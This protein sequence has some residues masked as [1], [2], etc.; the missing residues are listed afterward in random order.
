MTKAPRPLRRAPRVRTPRVGARRLHHASENEGFTLVEVLIALMVLALATMYLS[1]GLTTSAW[2]VQ[3]TSSRIAAN[4]IAQQTLQQAESL[5]YAT[6]SEGI[7]CP[8]SGSSGCTSIAR[9]TGGSTDSRIQYSG[10]C[11]YFGT[12]SNGLLIPTQSQTATSSSSDVPIIPNA[13]VA[14]STSNPSPSYPNPSV[15]K[16]S[17]QVTTY[18][19]FNTK[20]YTA[21]TCSSLTNDTA[22]DVPV[23]VVAEVSWANNS[24]HVS[25]QTVLYDPSQSSGTGLAANCPIPVTQ[26]GAHDE[27]LLADPTPSGSASASPGGEVSIFFLDEQPTP[28]TPTLCLIY[29]SGAAESSQ[30][31]PLSPC[32]GTGDTL[33]CWTD[34]A[35]GSQALPYQ[36]LSGTAVHA[37]YGGS[38]PNASSPP[39][40]GTYCTSWPAGQTSNPG[41]CDD[42]D[43]YTFKLPTET[44]S[45]T[46]QMTGIEVAAWDHEGDLDDW[47]WTVSAPSGC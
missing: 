18:P 44:C 46:P 36:N 15:N 14:A 22:P 7:S 13:T 33:P 2:S 28:Y 10:G 42:E 26:Q 9:Q 8:T 31:A 32:T 25:M 43:L 17:F 24:Q 41:S 35:Y 40:A 5:G 1:S 37:T 19:M 39:K 21:V 3:Q 16:V 29:G 27:A 4:E 30:L 6:V 12:P 23:I 11:A 45:S 20:R 38:G 34:Q 47:T